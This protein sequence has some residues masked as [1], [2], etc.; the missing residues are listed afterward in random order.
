VITELPHSLEPVT[1]DPF[2]AEFTSVEPATIL[3]R[4]DAIA[5]T[6]N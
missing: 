3:P 6:N 5:T 1:A 2:I 4:A